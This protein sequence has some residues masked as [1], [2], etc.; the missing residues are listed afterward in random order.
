MKRL[1]II[2]ILSLTLMGCNNESLL[3]EVENP[4]EETTIKLQEQAKKDTVFY[5]LAENK[6]KDLLILQNAE[7]KYKV[8]QNTD[9]FITFGWFLGVITVFFI[10][11]IIGLMG[12][13]D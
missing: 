4:Q 8:K 2:L 5:T 10:V 9:V 6:N 7:V 1:S 11:G 3:K 12:G 13:F